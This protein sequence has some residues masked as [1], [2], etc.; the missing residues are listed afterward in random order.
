MRGGNK[1]GKTFECVSLC[2]QYTYDT[3]IVGTQIC[4]HSHIAG[5]VNPYNSGRVFG[6][7]RGYGQV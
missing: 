6:L 1:R 7:R 5:D 4:L 2:T 3:D